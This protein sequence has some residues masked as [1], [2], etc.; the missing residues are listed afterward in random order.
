MSTTT[1]TRPAVE[2]VENAADTDPEPVEIEDRTRRALTEYQ[3]VFAE[4]NTPGMFTVIGEG[5]TYRL[6]LETDSCECPDARHRGALCKHI[7]RVR[8]T[9]GARDIPAGHDLENDT[10]LYPC[11]ASV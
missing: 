4:P 6:D 5:S 3:T 10:R 9:T 8:F 11:S 2:P 7:R 1:D